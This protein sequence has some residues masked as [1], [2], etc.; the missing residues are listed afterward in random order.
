MLNS[1]NE[2]TKVLKYHSNAPNAEP[3][4]CNTNLPIKPALSDLLC[5]DS[6]IKCFAQ[7]PPCQIPC[8]VATWLSQLA[9][10]NNRQ[11]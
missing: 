7:L 6:I 10:Q 8:N 5:G 9:E 11:K 2:V 3:S 1:D 4:V